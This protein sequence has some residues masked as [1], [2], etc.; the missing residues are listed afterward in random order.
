MATYYVKPGDPGSN[1]GTQANPWTSLASA[2]SA[3]A[4]GDTVYCQGIQVLSSI[5][6]TPTAGTAGL[7]ISIIGTNSAWQEDG[8]F[9]TLNGNSAV[10]NALTHNG[11]YYI[12]RNIEVKN[13][14]GWGVNSNSNYNIWRNIYMHNCGYGLVGGSYDSVIKC[15]I[16]SITNTALCDCVTV[17]NCVF[18]SI[19]G[20]FLTGFT[21]GQIMGNIFYDN[22]SYG[23]YPVTAGT[24]II[25]NTINNCAIGIYVTTPANSI[26]G[27]RITNN[28]TY[29]IRVA[30][31]TLTKED[32]NFFLG[33]GTNIYLNDATSFCYS[34]GNSIFAGTEG[35]TNKAGKVFNLTDAATGRRI[36]TKV[37][38]W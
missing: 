1:I 4:A 34:P 26:F 8:T 21:N 17:V 13:T 19:G 23:I 15:T 24:A 28:I 10:A 22:T 30:T 12:Y 32:Y 37:G 27:N 29:G 9:F 33:N 11:N 5:I 2:A 35:Y 31:N 18:Y 38:Q 7:P 25:N 36:M 6:T 20:N 3:V 16:G 14:T